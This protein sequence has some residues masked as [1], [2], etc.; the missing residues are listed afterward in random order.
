MIELVIL[1]VL[2]VAV[3]TIAVLGVVFLAIRLVIGLVLLPIR[4]LLLPLKLAGALVLAPVVILVAL[5]V[6]IP[7]VLVGLTA[8]LAP[9]TPLL[10]VALLVWLLAR[11]SRTRVTA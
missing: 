11:R 4:L 7:L 9:L 6:A 1:G 5:L 3:F 2:A 10:V 8:L